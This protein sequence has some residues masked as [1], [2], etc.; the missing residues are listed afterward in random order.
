V[1]LA[2]F[3]SNFLLSF[4]STVVPEVVFWTLVMAVVFNQMGI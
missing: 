2:V 4:K 1:P 3:V